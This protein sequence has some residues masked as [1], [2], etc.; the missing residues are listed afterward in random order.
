MSMFQNKGHYGR[1]SVTSTQE[2]HIKD[3]DRP[4]HV[5]SHANIPRILPRGTRPR[6]CFMPRI[7]QGLSHIG[8]VVEL[9]VCSRS[10]D[11]PI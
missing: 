4:S 5:P 1:Q 7:H 10:R 11:N 8:G 2:L 9:D 6:I 3:I